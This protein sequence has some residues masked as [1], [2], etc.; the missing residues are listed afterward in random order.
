MYPYGMPFGENC[1]NR[2]SWLTVLIVLFAFAG[3]TTHSED[4]SKTIIAYTR[5]GDP[6]ELDSTK[7]LIA[8]FME[9]NPDIIVRVDVVSWQQY[10]QKMATAVVT[11]TA[12]DV[13]LMSSSYIEQYAAAGHVLDLMPFIEKEPSFKDDDYF[14]RAFDNFTYTGTGR[15]MRNV[16]FRQGALYGFTRDYNCSL[17]YYNKDHFDAA[18]VPYPTNDWTWEDMA[19]AAQ[20]LTI[21]FDNDGIIDQW[22]CGG[23]TWSTFSAAMGAQLI[24]PETRRSN[25]SPRPGSSAIYDAILFD[26]DLLY[27]Y[28][29]APTPEVGVEEYAF[30]TGKISMTIE[31]AWE[32]RNYN[33]SKNLW[34]IAMVPLQHK[35]SKRTTGG[36]GVGHV[37]YSGTKSPEAAWRL[38]YFLSSDKSQRA[39]GRSG[40]SIPVLKSAAYSDDFLADFDRPSKA[41]YDIIY[42]NLMGGKFVPQYTRGYL[43]YMKLSRQLMQEVW[44]GVKTPKDACELIDKEVNTILDEEY[45][46]N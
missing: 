44:L 18:G 29:C 35:D 19:L 15:D 3:C 36:G 4:E 28:K 11:G 46:E 45:G 14:P 33:R 26:L 30:V 24:D 22:G 17:L 25:F 13:W 38:V 2:F 39:L 43:E 7:E 27:K 32:I 21:D 23:G 42:R 16:P 37:I 40:T 5:W 10:W 6:A 12:Q 8:Q 41:S 9:E 1:V 31:G 20:K 34:D